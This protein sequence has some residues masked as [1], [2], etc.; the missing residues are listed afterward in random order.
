MCSQVR[1]PTWHGFN[2]YPL[3]FQRKE[4]RQVKHLQ[5]L[6]W[7]GGELPEK[8]QDLTDLIKEVKRSSGGGD[9]NPRAMTTV[10][11]CK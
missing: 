10:V 1:E 7:S 4:S 8:P 5:F 2:F 6:K 3:R 11:H 9:G